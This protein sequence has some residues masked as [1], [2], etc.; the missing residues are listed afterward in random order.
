[1][2]F[3]NGSEHS[4]AY[5]AE[6]T[7]GTTPATP[8]FKELRH[9]GTTLGLSKETLESEELGGRQ[10]KCFKHGNQQVGG[11][12]NSELS[13]GDFDDLLEAA[14]C[15]TWETDTP[16]LGTDQLVSGSTRR[17]FTFQRF[18]A[19]I[20]T[21]IRSEGCE[22]NT[23]GMSVA[24]NAIATVDFGVVGLSQ[25]DDNA[26]IAGATS[27]AASA[28]CPFDSFTGTI[29]EGGSAIA[30][31]Q[32]I[33]WSLE[34]GIEPQ[35]IIGSK[36]AAEKS[37]GKSRATGTL[38]AYFSSVALMNKFINETSSSID[39]TLVDGAG[40]ELKFSFPNVKYNG[41][42]PDVSGDGP[43]TIALPFVA[44]YDET[45]GSQVVIERTAA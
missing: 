13:F 17:T 18:F 3:A 21:Y 26:A 19:D 32:Q 11:D 20:S 34:N 33:E 22:I 2:A 29:N 1:M 25:D 42:Q 6:V 44:L 16:S 10:V 5:V 39:Y 9:N 31:V 23:I 27:V 15:G 14:L 8:A 45:A 35:F 43:I 30:I 40:N 24:P 28:E 41:G 7:A 36:T 37:I 12:V 4:L 38:T